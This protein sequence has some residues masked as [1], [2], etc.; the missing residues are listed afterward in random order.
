[1]A[2]N[3]GR[4]SNSV[5]WMQGWHAATKLN[6]GGCPYDEGTW[7]CIHWWKGFNQCVSEKKNSQFI[8]RQTLNNRILA[9]MQR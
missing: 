3:G 5:P 7:K 6:G 8:E 4:Q 9:E 1:M 2:M